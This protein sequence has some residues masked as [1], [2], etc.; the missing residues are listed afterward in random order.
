MSNISTELL[1][2]KL[3]E[4][5][6][7]SKVQD[8]LGLSSMDEDSFKKEFSA[9]ETKGFIVRDGVRRGLK[10]KAS[11]T[12]KSGKITV[13]VLEES[14]KSKEDT[15]VAVTKP[16]SEKK[17][18]KYHSLNVKDIPA[19][20]TIFPQHEYIHEVTHVALTR[21]LS[22]I[23]DTQTEQRTVAIQRTSKG[24]TVKTYRNGFC[25]SEVI[26][27]KDNFKTLLTASNI[28]LD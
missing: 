13:P 9:L 12:I 1:A 11:D 7:S 14:S 20:V 5:T 2:E 3:A 6:L 23:L 18:A 17:K 19:E 16:K 25:L 26:Y 28:N 24:I 15:S 21:L 4:W 27:T 10:F 8:V 22:F